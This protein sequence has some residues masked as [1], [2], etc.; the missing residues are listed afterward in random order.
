MMTYTK[1]S[2]FQPRRANLHQISGSQSIENYEF[3]S[4]CFFPFFSEHILIWSTL[5]CTWEYDVLTVNE[6]KWDGKES[7]LIVLDLP[8]SEKQIAFVLSYPNLFLL[9]VKS[10]SPLLWAPAWNWLFLP[11][12]F[13]CQDSWPKNVA[14]KTAVNDFAFVTQAVRGKP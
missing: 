12:L 7:M 10:S 4:F 8:S 2:H 5:H 11:I 3:E 6:C 13:Q 1:L 14:S 9:H